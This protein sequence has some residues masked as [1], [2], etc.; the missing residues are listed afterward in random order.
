M[1]VVYRFFFFFANDSLKTTLGSYFCLN[2]TGGL[3]WCTKEL[4]RN[5]NR[6]DYSSYILPTNFTYFLVVSLSHKA[7]T[8]AT[9]N[10]DIDISG[11]L[12]KKR[13]HQNHHFY[14]IHCIFTGFTFETIDALVENAT[15]NYT[16]IIP[17]Q[18]TFHR[19]DP[20]P[21]PSIFHTDLTKE[22]LITYSIR[23]NLTSEESCY[24]YVVVYS[25]NQN[26]NNVLVDVIVN[27][28]DT[29]VSR[30]FSFGNH[31]I[32]QSIDATNL[33]GGQVRNFSFYINMSQ[34]H[35]YAQLDVQ[36]YVEG[37]NFVCSF[38]FF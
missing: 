34:C 11:I 3:Q 29:Y 12:T 13:N 10:V 32:L 5:I 27:T 28:S 33:L 2:P 35:V 1:A 9:I 21:I 31:S 23:S 38:S 30:I 6:W 8:N 19:F 26:A 18:L 24:F 4:V 36:F 37:E 7:N 16:L 25:R 17:S 14:S 15:I 22:S 20:P